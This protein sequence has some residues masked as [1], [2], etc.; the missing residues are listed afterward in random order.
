MSEGVP[1]SLRIVEAVAEREGIDPIDL[2]PPLHAAVDTEA[3]DTLFR[4]TDPNRTVTVEFSYRGYTVRIDGPD[5]VS[6]SEGELES[7]GDSRSARELS[8]D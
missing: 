6:V 4:S 7:A 1:V 8:G 3:L 5:A 2:K